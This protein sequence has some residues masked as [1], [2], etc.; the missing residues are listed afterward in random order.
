M[1]NKIK[2]I[3]WT[4]MPPCWTAGRRFLNGTWRPWNGPGRWGSSW[5]R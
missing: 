3:A 1:A 2:L 4:W 5:C